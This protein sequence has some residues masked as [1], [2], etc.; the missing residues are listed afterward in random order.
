MGLARDR[1][2][3]GRGGDAPGQCTDAGTPSGTRDSIVVPSDLAIGTCADV[4]V[5]IL[6]ERASSPASAG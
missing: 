4:T 1:H 2:L 6:R 5:E 3:V